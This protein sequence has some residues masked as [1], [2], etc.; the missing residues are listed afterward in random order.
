MQGVR[1]TVTDKHGKPIRNAVITINV[2]ADI[3]QVSPNSAIFK[4]NLPIGS[5]NMHVC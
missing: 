2:F 4:A 1:G 5:Y 3:Y